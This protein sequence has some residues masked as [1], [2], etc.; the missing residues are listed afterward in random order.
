MFLIYSVLFTI[1]V[2]VALPYAGWRY[3]ARKLPPNYWRERLGF[4][5]ESLSDF[6]NRSGP[7]DAIWFHAVSVGETLAVAKLVRGIRERWPERPIFVSH[8]TPAGREVGEKRLPS[9]AGRFYLP[10][11]WQWSVRRVLK[12]VRPAM[13]VIAETE[14]WPNLVRAAREAGARVVL[15]NARISD[16]SLLGYRL[17]RP[18]FRR[19]LQQIDW[20][21]A[22]TPLDRDRFQALG[23]RPERLSVVGNIKFDAEV[24]QLGSLAGRLGQ[25]FAVAGRGPVVIAASTMPDEEA[26]VVQA[27]EQIR[28]KHPRALLI[29]APRHPERFELVANILINQGVSFIRR[30]RIPAGEQ[31][32]AATI[33]DAEVLLLDTIGELAG[34]FGL[35]DVVFIGGSL[36]PAGGHNLVEPALWG[37]PIIFG[38]HMENFRDAAGL[39]LRS[40]AAI[41]VGDSSELA[42][43]T[44]SLLADATHRQQLGQAAQALAE[45][46]SGATRRILDQ[47]APWLETSPAVPKLQ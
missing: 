42:C 30:T 12:V 9:V 16:R 29:L 25:G 40:R 32:L 43:E 41:Q 26:L 15:V 38:P 36:V 7:R 5:P 18:F 34:I 8:V 45:R 20:I 6:A 23:A 10:L 35:A 22:Q 11:D 2:I 14:L 39:F 27:W 17:F 21:G 28:R 3:R 44:L 13:L 47:I 33:R 46:E 1:G 37:R 4:L 19:V 24:P 31:E